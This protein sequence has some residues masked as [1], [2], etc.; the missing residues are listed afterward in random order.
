MN[1]EWFGAS[2]QGLRVRDTG[3]ILPYT[4]CQ[5]SSRSWNDS[6]AAAINGPFRNFFRSKDRGLVSAR[7][8]AT[9]SGLILAIFI[10]GNVCF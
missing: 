2:G 10:V 6:W 8:S 4:L 1:T 9:E 5:S 7:E 3:G